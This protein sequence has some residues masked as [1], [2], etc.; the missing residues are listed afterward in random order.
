IGH[1]PKQ[2]VRSLPVSPLRRISALT[3]RPSRSSEGPP[4][5]PRKYSVGR[6]E[7]IRGLIK[8]CSARSALPT[9]QAFATIPRRKR[10]GPP[11]G[12]LTAPIAAFDLLTSY[13]RY[14]AFRNRTAFRI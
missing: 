10:N 4:N 1:A 8:K 3:L 5:E 12:G 13:C 11:A 2:A 14:A 9:P 6:T 7:A